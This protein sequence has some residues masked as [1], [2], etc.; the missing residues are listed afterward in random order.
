MSATRWIFEFSESALNV[1][2]FN[3]IYDRLVYLMVYSQTITHII[4]LYKG[5]RTAIH[6]R[7]RAKELILN[8]S[9]RTVFYHT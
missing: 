6:G 4:P 3:T 8:F 2:I 5:M 1:N 7:L 9:M